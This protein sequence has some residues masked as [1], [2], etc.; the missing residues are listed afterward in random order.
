MEG[1][2]EFPNRRAQLCEN[3]RLSTGTRPFPEA[4]ARGQ[5]ALGEAGMPAQTQ[6]VQPPGSN[7]SPLDLWDRREAFPKQPINGAAEP[8]QLQG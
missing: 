8:A 5:G 7:P 4:L 6:L 2:R 1:E 3:P